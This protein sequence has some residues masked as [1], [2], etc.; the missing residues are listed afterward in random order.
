ML[1]FIQDAFR[2]LYNVEAVV[3]WGGTFIV[4]AFVF[5]ETGLFVGFFLPGDSLL[6]TAGVFA[7]AGLLDLP[8]LLLFTTICA[9]AGDQTGF[10][11]GRSLG[12]ALYKKE[13]SF[14]FRR[15][16]LMKAHDFYEKYG[17]KTI[18]LARF[19]PIV[20]TFAPAVAGAAEMNYRKFVTYN[21][22]GGILWVE[23][24]V[25]AGYFLGKSIPDIGKH[26]HLVIA[27]VIA[28]SFLPIVYELWKARSSRKPA[29]S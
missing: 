26:I 17:P 6:V 5:I 7:A 16:H 21:V 2:T 18:V 29:A 9:V 12:H 20:R 14:F 23:G 3:R 25:L 4:C 22:F 8:T 13:D 10:W 28:L 24:V 1:D 11:I 27:V 15:S 19:I